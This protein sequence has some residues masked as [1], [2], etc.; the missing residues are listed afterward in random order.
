MTTGKLHPAVL[1][2]QQLV[3]IDSQNPTTTEKEIIGFIGKLLSESGVPYELQEVQK[4]RSNLIAKI[5]GAQKRP[6]IVIVAHTDTVPIG[7]GW[8]EKPLGGEIRDGKLYGRGAA[9]MKAGLAAALYA[10]C[11]AADQKEELPGDFIV[12]ASVDEEGPGMAGIKALL[13]SGVIGK[14]SL[15]IAPE[16]T[17]LEVVR[18]HR[19]VMWYEIAT[20]GVSAHGGH[21]QRGV[22]ANHAMVEVLSEIKTAVAALPFY[23]SLL[24][25]PLVSIG[26]MCGGEKTNVVPNNARAEIDFRIV[27]PLT[28]KDANKLINN[29]AQRA[30][31]RVPGASVSVANLGMQ[32]EPILLEENAQIIQHLTRSFCK[33]MGKDPIHSGYVAYTDAAVVSLLTGNKTSIC[34]GPGNLE[35]GHT[36]DEWAPVEEIEKCAEIF[37]ELAKTE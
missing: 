32:R 28:A 17:S 29:C 23:D 20:K 16:P 7:E 37:F 26:H 25:Q 3:Q 15:V 13:D 24:K 8:T 6:P 35:Q 36:L 11:K 4:D 14:D 10:V 22:D 12:I 31:G 2:T 19:G 21:A 30:I 1:L 18:A 33:V 9:D 27:P 34:F 5:K